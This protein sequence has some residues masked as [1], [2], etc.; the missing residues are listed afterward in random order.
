MLSEDW[1][2]IYF[3]GVIGNEERYAWLFIIITSTQ[4]IISEEYVCAD[5]YSL[6]G[7]D[8]CQQQATNFCLARTL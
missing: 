1:Q 4:Y 3:N 8:K 6:Y 5:Y 2:Y 7:C